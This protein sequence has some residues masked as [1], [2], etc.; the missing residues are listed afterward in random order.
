MDEIAD[1]LTQNDSEP[2]KIKKKKVVIAILS[3]LLVIFL[4]LISFTKILKNPS[5][6]S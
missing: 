1:D 2:K 5:D 3:L 6:V 4:I